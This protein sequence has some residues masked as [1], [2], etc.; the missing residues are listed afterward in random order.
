MSRS[1]NV[2]I[3]YQSTHADATAGWSGYLLVKSD[4]DVTPGTAYTLKLEDGR[5][6]RLRIEKLTS[7]DS[8]KFQAAFV[9][10][11]SLG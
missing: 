8:D 4:K 11:G 7:D 2:Y 1:A 5:S 10:E 9:G 3:D 6:G